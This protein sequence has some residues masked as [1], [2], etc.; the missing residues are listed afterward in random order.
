[1]TGTYMMSLRFSAHC[2]HE[3]HEKMQAVLAG[4]AVLSWERAKLCVRVS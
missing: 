2:V 4:V 1:M 3:W